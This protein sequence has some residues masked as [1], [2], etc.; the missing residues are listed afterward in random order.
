[1]M[2]YS[3]SAGAMP[4]DEAKPNWNWLQ[5]RVD[6][7]SSEMFDAWVDCQ[8]AELEASFAEYMTDRSRSRAQR[9]QFASERD[10]S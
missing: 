3:D 2:N 7:A 6:P 4:A 1:M 9:Q 8:L 10:R 5:R